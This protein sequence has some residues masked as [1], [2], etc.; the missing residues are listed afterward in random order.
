[1]RKKI[2][3]LVFTFVSTLGSAQANKSEDIEENIK[4]TIEN[5]TFIPETKNGTLFNDS[6]KEIP[7]NISFYYFLDSEKLFSVLYEQHDEISL[8]KTFYYDND[9]LVLIVIEKINNKAATDRIVEQLFYFYDQ[10]T[11]ID[12][13]DTTAPY[14]PEE[15]LKEGMK[16]LNE[17]N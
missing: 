13:S 8:N 14:I 1:M 3:I 6:G 16:Y 5:N 9:Q 4:F 10:G 11:L 15:L 17:F 12:A 2:S 7:Y